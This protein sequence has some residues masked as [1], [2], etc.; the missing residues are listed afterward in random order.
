MN[1]FFDPLVKE[2]AFLL[3]GEEAWHGVKVMRLKEGSIMHITD[4][5]GKIFEAEIIGINKKNECAIMVKSVYKTHPPKNPSL[6]IA[7]APT[8]SI[9]RF[10]WFLE[11][12]TECG[13]TEITPI[14]CENSERTVIKPERLEKIIVAAMKQSLRAWLPKLNPAV[15]FKTLITNVNCTK[16]LIAHCADDNKQTIE[17]ACTK[18]DDTIIVIGPEGD[19]SP[20]EITLALEKSYIPISLG[21]YRL[22]TET[23]ALFAC[24]TINN[25][26]SQK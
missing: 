23:A 19:F 12:A 8:K 15:K 17:Q 22:R 21:Q 9:D 26:I 16:K 6:H 24:I 25:I 4:G 20:E 2:G 13:I 5:N 18:G 3:T 14:I 7:I 11:K 10:E 1:I